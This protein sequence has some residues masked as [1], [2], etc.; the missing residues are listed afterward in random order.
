MAACSFAVTT[1]S[2]A[3]ARLIP[4]CFLPCIVKMAPT[5][6]VSPDNILRYESLPTKGSTTVLNICAE[7]GSSVFLSIKSSVLGS[8]PMAT[9]KYGVGIYSTMPSMSFLI[10][11]FWRAEPQKTGKIFPACMPSISA[12]LTSSSVISSSAIYFSKSSLL[13]SATASMSF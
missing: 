12:A 13:N 3:C 10:P 8:V 5:R 11:A 9:L 2:P 7:K 1:I 6:S 4:S